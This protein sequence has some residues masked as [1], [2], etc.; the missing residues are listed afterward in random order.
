MPEIRDESVSL[1]KVEE[2]K[3]AGGSPIAAAAGVMSNSGKIAGRK[4]EELR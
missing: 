1:D 4:V 3:S 2:E